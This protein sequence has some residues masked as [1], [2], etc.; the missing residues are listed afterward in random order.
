MALQLYEELSKA[1]S[2]RLWVVVMAR[3]RHGRTHL[4]LR[5]YG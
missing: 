2:L 4:L 5:N 3:Y 1:L